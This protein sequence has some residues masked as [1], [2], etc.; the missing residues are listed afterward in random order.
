M[1][2]KPIE[3]LALA[4]LVPLKATKAARAG[5]ESGKYTVDFNVRIHG[6]INVAKDTDKT[7]TCSLSPLMLAAL[8]IKGRGATDA[9]F[10]AKLAELMRSAVAIANVEAA[11]ATGTMTDEQKALDVEM[12]TLAAYIKTAMKDVKDELAKL[13]K[14]G[15]DGKVTHKLEYAE[16]TTADSKVT[17]GKLRAGVEPTATA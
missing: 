16:V 12:S 2:L 17:T 14:T 1:P 15:V 9:A 8:A 11:K 3:E 10:K 4:K 13:P 6:S 7:P 5:V